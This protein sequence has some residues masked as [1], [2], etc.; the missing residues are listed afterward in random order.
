MGMGTYGQVPKFL[1]QL[2]A[3]EASPQTQ[4]WTPGPLSQESHNQK[5]SKLTSSFI[6]ERKQM[7]SEGQ[8][9][10]PE[11]KQMSLHGRVKITAVVSAVA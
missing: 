2:L 3:S 10:G 8:S 4:C 7:G 11:A 6:L 9:S 1:A 5:C